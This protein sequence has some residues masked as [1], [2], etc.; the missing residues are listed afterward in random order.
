[1]S[2]TTGPQGYLY[3]EYLV[4]LRTNK[5][6]LLSE[7]L[8]VII[9]PSTIYL[10]NSKSV[11]LEGLGTEDDPIVGELN[12]DTTVTNALTITDKGIK[13]GLSTES[14]NI[15]TLKD[16]LLYV[17][18]PEVDIPI[19]PKAENKV[20]YLTDAGNIGLYVPDMTFGDSPRDGNAYV[21]GDG[22]WL[23]LDIAVQEAPKDDGYYV[24]TNGVWKK[25][26][27]Y[28]LAITSATGSFNVATSQVFKL[29]GSATTNINFSN[30][31]TNRAMTIV[32]IVN[33]SGGTITWPST[34]DW[35]DGIAP[36]LATTRT[37]FTIF[38]D[39]VNLTGTISAS[40]A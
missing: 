13:V 28:D 1:M 33:G 2:T 36:E 31:P 19:S 11:K 35:S 25:L 14:D 40:I 5:K 30:L 16:G 32:V 18:R 37:I 24:R 4:D 38:W 12:L 20:S 6:I 34:I 29:N 26:D 7:L 8:D 21:R 23:Q 9:N 39:G 17:K 22:E 3:G 27:R 15:A 10:N